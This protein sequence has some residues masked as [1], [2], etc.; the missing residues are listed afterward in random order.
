MKMDNF[1][2]FLSIAKVEAIELAAEKA[3]IDFAKLE[4][5][6]CKD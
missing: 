2:K 4:L 6:Q 5:N 3:V 1:L